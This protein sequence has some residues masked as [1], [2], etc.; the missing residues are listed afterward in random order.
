ML[1]KS[2]PRIFLRFIFA[3]L[4]IFSILLMPCC[5][6]EANSEDKPIIAVTIVPEHTF[7]KEVC[8][9]L[10]QIVTLIAPGYSPESYEPAP[11]EIERFSKADLYFTIGVAVEDISILPSV[12]KDIKVISLQNEVSAVYADRMFSENSRD[13]HIWL[14]PKRVKIMIAAISREVSVLDPENADIYNKNAE[15]YIKRLSELEKYIKNVIGQMENK[16]FIAF[17]PAFGYFAEDFGL[18]M[19][20]LQEEGKDAVPRH[21]QEMIDLS[22][23]EGIKAIFYQEEIDSRQAKAFA[24]EIGGKTVKLAPLSADY[25]DNLILMA[26]TLAE[27]IK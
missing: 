15:N 9:D 3:A 5:V 8:G 27:V 25:I 19:Y 18:T 22:K 23:K 11:S 21:L 1:Q 12:K 14:S 13:P 4:V 16:K 7:V 20:A 26:D 2:R 24:K 17:H 6:R 10:V